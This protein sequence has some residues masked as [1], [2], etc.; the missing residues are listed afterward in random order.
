MVQVCQ[1]N[2]SANRCVLWHSR[3]LPGGTPCQAAF[4]QPGPLRKRQKR[5]FKDHFVSILEQS[6]R[7]RARTPGGGEKAQRSPAL[8]ESS[9]TNRGSGRSW[10][11]V[12]LLPVSLRSYSRRPDSRKSSQPLQLN[13]TGESG[14][15]AQVSQGSAR[16]HTAAPTRWVIG[17]WSR[18]SLLTAA[19]WQGKPV[20]AG[21]EGGSRCLDTLEVQTRAAGSPTGTTSVG[22]SHKCQALAPS[23]VSRVLPRSFRI[24]QKFLT[25]SGAHTRPN[26]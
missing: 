22:L 13:A 24:T 20:G 15:Q 10:L 19:C 4:I 11:D 2:I 23:Q 25:Q 3:N 5:P 14:G 21:S 6:P 8:V 7:G 9:G 1:G 17:R 18:R 26:S 12:T 16:G